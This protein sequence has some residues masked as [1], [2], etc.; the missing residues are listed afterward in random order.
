MTKQISA[1]YINLQ[2]QQD[3][4]ISRVYFPSSYMES[5]WILECIPTTWALQALDI[6]RQVNGYQLKMSHF[7][8]IAIYNLFKYENINNPSHIFW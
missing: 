1:K 5:N 4:L 2:S 3:D 7:K 6:K 8:V